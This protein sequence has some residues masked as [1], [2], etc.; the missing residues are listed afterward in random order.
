[1]KPM[2]LFMMVKA[3]NKDKRQMDI[4]ANTINMDRDNEVIHPKAY[5]KTVPSFMENPV[6]LAAHNYRGDA[7]GKFV[8]MNVEESGLKGR[9]EFAP[10]DDGEKYWALYSGGYQRAFS[11]GFMPRVFKIN[12]NDL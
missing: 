1:M 12:R 6:L 3:I 8:D 7:V 11:V 4:V 2:Q 5:T 10:T 9:V